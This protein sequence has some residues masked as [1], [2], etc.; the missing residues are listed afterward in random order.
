[1][2][3]ACNEILTH[4]IKASYTDYTLPSAVFLLDWIARKNVRHQISFTQRITPES[5]SVT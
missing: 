1:M 4:T 3:S 2:H 5:T